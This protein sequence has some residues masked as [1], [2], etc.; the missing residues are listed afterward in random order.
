MGISKLTSPQ[1]W[2][3]EWTPGV[4]LA[5][6]FSL[7]HSQGDVVINSATNLPTTQDGPSKVFR[8]GALTINAPLSF[9]S[10][11]RPPIILCESLTMGA[12]G[13]FVLDFLGARGES[14]WPV[15]DWV[16]PQT[17]R[18]Q[19][20]RATYQ[21]AM[22][23]IAANGIFVGDPVFWSLRDPAL[24][25]CVGTLVS[26]FGAALIGATGCGAGGIAQRAPNPS[27]SGSFCSGNPGLAGTNAP[28]GGG[29]G[30][31]GSGATS[32]SGWG[33]YGGPGVPWSGGAPATGAYENVAQNGWLFGGPGPT[34][35]RPGGCALI[36]CRGNATLVSGHL[37]SAKGEN[38]A[39]WYC[40]APGGGRVGLVYGG[41]LTGTFNGVAT[42]GVTSG[43][44]GS[45]GG[46]GV[47]DIRTFAQM[48]WV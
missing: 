46:T 8:Y 17:L 29:G 31:A 33:G 23:F 44:Y 10:R 48:G 26:P 11:S 1:A 3:K 14:S 5:N 30:G 9:T 18:L 22:A 35:L 42:G 37:F 25:D 28:G 27:A 36:I 2:I 16:I 4:G 24:A 21:E 34:G 40:G 7:Y 32:Q 15:S 45:N 47:A 20:R 13:Q 39:N 19:G 6:L 38:N 43:T 12:G 41:T